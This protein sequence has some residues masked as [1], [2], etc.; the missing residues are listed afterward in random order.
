[1]MNKFEIGSKVQGV[2]DLARTLSGQHG[3]FLASQPGTQLVIVCQE[4]YSIKSIRTTGASTPVIPLGTAGV[5]D[6]EKLNN[7][8]EIPQELIGEPEEHHRERQ[9]QVR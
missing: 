4:G 6:L 5:W 7:S 1:M 2:R 9:A 8:T 3:T